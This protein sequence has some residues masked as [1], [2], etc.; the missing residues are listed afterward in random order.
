MSIGFVSVAIAATVG[1][2]VGAIA[3]FSGGTV[4]RLLMWFTDLLLSLPRLVLLLAIIG[5]VRVKGVGSIFL[6]VAILGLTGWMGVA[7]I[8]RGQVLSLK[9]Q[10]FIQAAHAL[11]YQSHRIIFRHLVPNAMAPVIVY[12]SL[13]IGGTML[14]E[15]GLSF[16][17]LGLSLIHI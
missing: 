8:V 10:E 3:A 14:A 2:S 15:A 11:G 9:Q 17:G 7:R 1:T 5:L 12:C 13:A 6:I 16:L 4:D